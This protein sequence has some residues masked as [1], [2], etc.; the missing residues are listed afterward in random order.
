MIYEGV[1]GLARNQVR[2]TDALNI[3]LKHVRLCDH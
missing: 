3:E 2:L 1:S